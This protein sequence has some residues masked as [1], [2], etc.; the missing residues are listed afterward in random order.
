M[1]LAAA[2]LAQEQFCCQLCA[3]ANLRSHSYFKAQLYT[4][5]LHGPFGSCKLC[6]N[7]CEPLTQ[8]PKHLESREVYKLQRNFRCNLSNMQTR[9][10][11]NP[12]MMSP[13]PDHYICIP[14]LRNI[15]PW[16]VVVLTTL[17]PAWILTGF[18]LF[19]KSWAPFGYRL[20]YG[21]S[22]SKV[23]KW[24]PYFENYPFMPCCPVR[25]QSPEPKT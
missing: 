24:D 1:A 10:D 22:Y 6:Q 9:L 3:K 5:Q 23:P 11:F 18:G 2:L 12:C 7:P 8:G 25:A 4:M 14:T 20:L 19:S 17:T 16:A 15:T 21:T 13:K